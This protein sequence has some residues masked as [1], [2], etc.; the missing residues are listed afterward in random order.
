MFVRIHPVVKVPVNVF[1]PSP[2]VRVTVSDVV[3]LSVPVYHDVMFPVTVYIAGWLLY[4]RK[5]PVV[6]F[7]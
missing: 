5:R 4:N 2:P 1:S 3:V 6:V 7:V